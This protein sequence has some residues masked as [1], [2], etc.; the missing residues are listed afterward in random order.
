MA[1]TGTIPAAA[2]HWSKV[3]VSV[4]LFLR[5]CTSW[6]LT[7]IETIYVRS[8]LTSSKGMDSQ[9]SRTDVGLISLSGTGSLGKIGLTFGAIY[10]E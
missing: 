10:K 1:K 5:D 2:R 9:V 3:F 4:S 6:P 7:L 8:P